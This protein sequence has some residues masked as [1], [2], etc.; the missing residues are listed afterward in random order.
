MRPPTIHA[1]RR[2]HRDVRLWGIGNEKNCRIYRVP[3]DDFSR[4]PRSGVTKVA[5]TT[6]EHTQLT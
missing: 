6:S 2:S 3:S 4:Q 5:T 1:P